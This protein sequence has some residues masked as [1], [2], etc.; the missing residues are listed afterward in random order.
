M[1]LKKMNQPKGKDS[2]EVVRDSENMLK[3]HIISPQKTELAT[4]EISNDL[5]VLLT[6]TF[7]STQ[8]LTML[9]NDD[10]C[11]HDTSSRRTIDS[12]ENEVSTNSHKSSATRAFTQIGLTAPVFS[13]TGDFGSGRFLYVMKQNDTRQQRLI[14]ECTEKKIIK[15]SALHNEWNVCL[16]IENLGYSDL[17]L[18]STLIGQIYCGE[19]QKALLTSTNDANLLNVAA[20]SVGSPKELQ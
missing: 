17:L 15:S 20:A 11:H 16:E 13:L 14:G 5:R 9:S 3:Y 4:T 2:L 19:N 8:F 10:E 12:S 1:Q 7:C 6:P 18:V